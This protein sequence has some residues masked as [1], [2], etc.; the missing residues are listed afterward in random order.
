MKLA[1]IARQR[2][3][4]ALLTLQGESQRTTALEIKIDGFCQGE[5]SFHARASLGQAAATCR[6]SGRFTLA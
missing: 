5:R 2:A 1:G 6:K 4:D 3:Q